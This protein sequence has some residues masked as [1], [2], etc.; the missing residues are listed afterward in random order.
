[1]NGRYWPLPGSRFR[2]SS[3]LIVD[4]LRPVCSAIARTPAPAARRSAIRTR[5]FSDRYRSEISRPTTLPR[6]TTAA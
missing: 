4:G 3:R 1:M 6:V 5:S 2:R